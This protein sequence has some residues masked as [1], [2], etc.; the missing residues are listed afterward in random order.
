MGTNT[1]V[2]YEKDVDYASDTLMQKENQALS[3]LEDFKRANQAKIAELE[4]NNK[5]LKEIIAGNHQQAKA[6]NFSVIVVA[7]D[8][9][10]IPDEK[11]LGVQ[12]MEK[13]GGRHLQLKVGNA[14]LVKAVVL[15]D[16]H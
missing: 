15:P 8:K 12:I 4:E 16:L 13:N 1:E 2:G 7:L 6:Y 11:F 14:K 9:F 5:A 3:E 10:T